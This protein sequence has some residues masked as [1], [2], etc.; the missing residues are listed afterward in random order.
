M[1]VNFTSFSEIID[2]LV[3]VN[4]NIIQEEFP[5]VPGIT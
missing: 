1:A 2:K 5:Q 3:R 4:I